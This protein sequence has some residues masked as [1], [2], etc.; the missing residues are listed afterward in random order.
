[1]T[2][3]KTSPGLEPRFA[4]GQIV[5]TPGALAACSNQYLQQCLAVSRSKL[6]PFSPFFNSRSPF[7]VSLAS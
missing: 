4:L 6:S 2:S 5:S 1:M 3:T 7:W